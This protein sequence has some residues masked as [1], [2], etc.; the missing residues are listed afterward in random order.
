MHCIIIALIVY[1]FCNLCMIAVSSKLT[2][3]SWRIFI[4]HIT[5]L[6]QARIP[7]Q[8]MWVLGTCMYPRTYAQM[9]THDLYMQPL[10]KGLRIKK[11]WSKCEIKN[12]T[13]M[14]TLILTFET[15]HVCDWKL[16]SLKGHVETLIKSNNILVKLT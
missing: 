6:F 8:Y 3:V 16:P 15:H 11:C 12:F 13:E 10:S 9:N 5:L 2:L 7:R 4:L 14:S 1:Y